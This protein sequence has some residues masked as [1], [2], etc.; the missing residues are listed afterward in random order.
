MLKKYL[1]SLPLLLV[2]YSLA[3]ACGGGSSDNPPGG[4][5]NPP[6]CGDG[7]LA[8]SEQCDDGNTTS[9]DGCT[10]SCTVET[11]PAVCGNGVVES[12]EQCDDG[13]VANGD[14]CSASCQ[15]EGSNQP[16][17][18]NGII[19]AG[20]QCDDS[21]TTSGD[22]C[23]SVCTVE[24]VS[25][26]CGNGTLEGAEQC[27]DGNANNGD[28][29]S[30]TCTKENG[31]AC[32]GSPS[33]CAS[34]C[35]DGI[36]VGAEQCDDGNQNAN[37]GCDLN[38]KV[39]VYY[40]C[41]GSPSVCSPICRDNFKTSTEGCDDGNATNGDGC[42][43]TCTPENG[44]SC[45]GS[46]FADSCVTVCGDGI[47][48]GAEQCD[49]GNTKN[50]DGCSACVINNGFSCVGSP[51]TCT[52]TCGD[53]I[54]AGAEACDD[55]NTANTDGCSSSCAIE[56][57]YGCSGSPSVC[58][59]TQG[60]TIWAYPFGDISAQAGKAVTSDA[61][62]NVIV[63]GDFAGTIN[64]GGS[65]LTSNGNNDIF[66]AKFNSDGQHQWSIS[67]G[68]SQSD[69]ITN[70]TTDANNDVLIAGNFYG[71]ISIGGTNLSAA[72]QD[73][74]VAKLS[75]TSGSTIWAQKI[76]GTSND[77]AN[78]ISVDSQL[79]V[80][81]AGQFLSSTIT[82]PT[83]PTT[84]TRKGKN[85]AL[86]IKL[87]PSGNL[88]WAKS[89]YSNSGLALLAN[90]KSVAVDPS[91]NSIVIGGEYNNS[92]IFESAQFNLTGSA[93]GGGF[94]AKINSN[95]STQWTQRF[96]GTNSSSKA[97]TWGVAIDSA[98]HVIATG[99]FTDVVDFGGGSLAATGSLKDIFLAQFDSSGVHQWSKKFGDTSSQVGTSLA[100]DA[101]NHIFLTGS[102][103]G[104]TDFGTGGLTSA[105]GSDLF[106]AKF[107]SSGFALWAKN[108]GDSLNQSSN[109][110]R[111]D[112]TGN[113]LLTGSFNGVLTLG[114][115]TLTSAGSTD[116]F[117]A[118]ISP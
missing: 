67:F 62:G 97:I 79:N 59:V 43:A 105:G 100:V 76:G 95:G 12:S 42:S 15:T 68:S 115:V 64:Y 14:G 47:K 96:A 110:I 51:S 52:T 92:L 70:V 30:T 28:G 56:T 1:A 45:T 87:D 24:V 103:D 93:S 34:T 20:E 50:G 4:S 44:Y 82:I 58:G 69:S 73:I 8:T 88:V 10:S 83:P 32:S 80:L 48:V 108:Y 77:F 49:D 98:H 118:K 117:V 114:S 17:C 55:G 57:G 104:F 94:I 6:I 31:Y 102:M 54:V 41:A 75:G 90:L 113:L 74:F 40:T 38:C 29:C 25:A 39:S 5:E 78:A 84:L 65:N 19:E 23:S 16:V 2:L 53:G 63:V 107:D 46:G 33:A 106:V 66:V 7:T 99:E 9:G 71:T 109:S 85:D 3:P 116:I 27:D 111:V 101:S 86:L 36:V 11:P 91:D 61:A 81:V 35:G 89:Y 18:G 22:G 60:Q 26:I 21:N 112:S 13:N 37:D 72:S